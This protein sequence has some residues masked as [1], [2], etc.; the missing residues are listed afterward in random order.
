MIDLH[1]HILPALDDG[2]ESLRE[3][4]EMAQTAVRNGTEI[5][6]ATPHRNLHG[7]KRKG[8]DDVKAAFEALKS[9]IA[10]VGL[11]LKVVLGSE[12][13]RSHDMVERLEAGELLTI[14]STKYVLVEFDFNEEEQDIFTIVERLTKHGYIPVVAHPERYTCFYTNV[15]GLYDLYKSGAVLQIN[16]GSVLGQFGKRVQRVAD[17]ALSHRLAAVAASDAHDTYSRDTDLSEFA[18]VLDI[19]YGEGCSPLLLEENPRRIIEGREIVWESPV[20]IE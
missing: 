9:G 19:R 20:P 14:N 10:V 11:N 6:V 13:F 17:I 7:A 16:K 18:K 5:I 15:G 2:A 3:S 8:T 1:T 12:N 4:L